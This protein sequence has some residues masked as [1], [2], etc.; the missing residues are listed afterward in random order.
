MKQAFP[1]LKLPILVLLLLVGTSSLSAQ[2]CYQTF[3][4]EGKKAFASFQFETAIKKFEA[5]KVCGDRPSSPVADEWLAKAQN[6]F[7]DR[8]QL[9]D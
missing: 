2:D 6:G 9:I 4:E 7:I 8:L 3:L 1:V 5:A